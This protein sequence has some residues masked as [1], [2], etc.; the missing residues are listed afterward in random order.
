MV[1]CTLGVVKFGL[2]FLG[3][4]AGMPAGLS[5][6]VLQSQAI[7]TALFAAVLLR[8]RLTARR[9]AVWPWPS[10]GSGW[11]PWTRGSAGRSVRSRW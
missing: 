11:R 10:A 9:M 6:L 2:L 5:S 4:H 3:M 8:E 7:F 1:G